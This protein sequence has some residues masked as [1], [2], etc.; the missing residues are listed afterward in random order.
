MRILVVSHIVQPAET[1]L[2]II[3]DMLP[4]YAE[5]ELWLYEPVALHVMVCGRVVG[6]DDMKVRHQDTTL[7]RSPQINMGF[8]EIGET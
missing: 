7:Q 1:Q 5:K 8:G 2:E 6:I 4:S 3:F